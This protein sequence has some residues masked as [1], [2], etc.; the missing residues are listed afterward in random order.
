MQVPS[1]LLLLALPWAAL[2][3]SQQPLYLEPSHTVAG[4]G[5]QLKVLSFRYGCNAVFSHQ[6]VA[7]SK[8][9]LD[10]AFVTQYT[11][12]ACPAVVQA[13]GPAFDVAALA[14]GRYDVYAN[15]RAPCL[16]APQ[17]C[18]IP[19]HEEFAGVLTVDADGDAWFISPSRVRA[20]QSFTLSLL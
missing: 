15:D 16:V 18:E 9:R 10:V 20:Q 2:A 17:P 12:I 1:L 3:Q 7:V 6:T 14:A 5:F 13:Y 4:Q 11:R 19:E 8:G